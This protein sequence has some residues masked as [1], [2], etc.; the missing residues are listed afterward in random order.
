MTESAHS[1][2]TALECIPAPKNRQI[3]EE[4]IEDAEDKA[5]IMLRYQAVMEVVQASD[6]LRNKTINLWA[7]RLEVSKRTLN[8][9]CRKVELEG[10]AALARLTRT[11]AGV[12][13]G[14][15][16]WKGKKVDEWVEFIKQTYREN[17][18]YARSMSRNQVFLQVMGHAE[19]ELGLTDSSEYP[20][21]GFVYQ[22]LEPLLESKKKK[23]NPG[24][25]P[26]I[27][28]KVKNTAGEVEEIVVTRSNQVWQIDHTR[29][30]NLLDANGELAGTIWLT[31]IIDT[32]SS[33]VM[34]YHL[35]FENMGSHE[36]ALALRHAIARKNYGAEYKL[37]KTWEACGLP[38]YIV[39]DS[40]KEFKS[41]HLR[42][43]SLNLDI[44]LRLRLYTEQGAIIERLFLGTKN[45]FCAKLPG[46]KGGSLRERP[47]HP[48][49]YAC[50][51]YE[52]YDRLLV[53]HIVDHR[54]AHLYPRI[55]NQ[56]CQERWRNGL[57]GGKP[58][59]PDSDR[60]LD[61]CLMKSTVRSIQMYGCIEF[62]SIVYG[63]GWSKDREG[64]WRYDR[65]RDFLNDWQGKVVLR[66]NPSNIVYLYVYSKEMSGQPSKYL[67]TIR[68]KHSQERDLYCDEER[69]SL[70]EWKERK[71][72]RRAE[73]KS[74]DRS[75]ISSEQRDLTQY[76]AKKVE[77]HNQKNRKTQQVKKD[78]QARI[79]RNSDRSKVIEFPAIPSPV[80]GKG[81]GD[82]CKD[83]KG[84]RDV[85][86]A[87]NCM[88]EPAKVK[89]QAAAFVIEDLNKFVGDDW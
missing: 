44:K 37:K 79:T 57:L 89:V 55:K 35:S 1:S 4:S 70:K 14:S 42:Q 75:S 21:R 74:V 47:P 34:G 71:K 87:V 65:N 77:A 15:K 11:D 19:L 23:R 7:Q 6:A 41:A 17:N 28:I 32:H 5:K 84:D 73:S 9:L 3:L 30:D 82:R 58:R 20:S 54:N 38:E 72:K 53:R 81:N 62:E 78:E 40:A 64:L 27:V 33:C 61:I 76:S 60:D 51:S 59:M 39:T 56:T 36:V 50:V 29:L 45:E 85:K 13:K 24:Q 80:R 48:E 66:Y 49:K 83:R 2:R 46:Y 63:A 86:T 43:V 69:L 67:G 31:G 88:T 52:E 8:R 26:G 22:I 18:R 16:Q 25:G 68:A 12:V 10:V